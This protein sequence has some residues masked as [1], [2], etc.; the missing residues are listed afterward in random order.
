MN[1]MCCGDSCP[2]KKIEVEVQSNGIIRNSKGYLI[3]RLSEE[4]GYSSEHIDE[5]GGHLSKQI[6]RLANY[7]MA[8]HS[9]EIDDNGACDVAIKIMSKSCSCELQRGE[10]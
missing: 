2:V 4:I 9:E 1:E 3:G 10:E 5:S 6:D 7:I 8:N